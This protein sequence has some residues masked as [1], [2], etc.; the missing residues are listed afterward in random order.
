ML[1]FL[2]ERAGYDVL[3]A[4]NGRD[5]QEILKTVE[6][7]SLILLDLMLPYVSG[8]QILVDAKENVVWCDIPILVLSG[9]ALECDVVKALDLGANDYVS[10]PFRPQELLARSRRLIATG[11]SMRKFGE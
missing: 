7:T 11:D 2:F 10:K 3:I 1:E 5:A 9:K 8:Y 6:P 4:K